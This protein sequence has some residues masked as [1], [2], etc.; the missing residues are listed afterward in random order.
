MSNA[1]KI[2]NIIN[3]FIERNFGGITYDID[4]DFNLVLDDIK[5]EIG[6]LKEILKEKLMIKN[7]NLDTVNKNIKN[8]IS[9]LKELNSKYEETINELEK[10][11][12]IN[13]NKISNKY[14]QKLSLNKN[15]NLDNKIYSKKKKD[16][17]NNKKKKK[18]KKN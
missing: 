8:E 15:I 17:Y 18:K 2:N 12:K 13:S 1:K 4:I 5:E 10:D 9:E 7:E 6:T 11:E 14:I 3:D 16:Y